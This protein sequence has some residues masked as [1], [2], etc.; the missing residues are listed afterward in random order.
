MPLA[1]IAGLPGH[2][3]AVTIETVH[4]KVIVPE[5]RRGSE[6]MDRLCS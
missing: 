1:D 5:L 3:G 4:G 2:K 6:V